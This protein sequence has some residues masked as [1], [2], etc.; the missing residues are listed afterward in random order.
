MGVKRTLRQ[1]EIYTIQ[2]V[3]P[4]LPRPALVA[5]RCR[6]LLQ[7]ADDHLPRHFL[8]VEAILLQGPLAG[9]RTALQGVRLLHA[10]DERETCRCRAYSFPHRTGKGHCRAL[11][12][13]PFCGECGNEATYSTRRRE[14]EEFVGGLSTSRHI[15]RS[16]CCGAPLFADCELKVSFSED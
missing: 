3:L 10:A 15:H 16:T 9:Q 6:V 14:P 8:S 12:A 1:N 2:E 11:L 13:G 7:M 5:Y 4:P